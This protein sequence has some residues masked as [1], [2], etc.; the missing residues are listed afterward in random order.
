MGP[1]RKSFQQELNELQRDLIKMASLVERVIHDAVKSL[2]EKDLEL[3]EKIVEGDD[4]ID[5]FNLSIEQK[6][7]QLLALQQPMASDLRL[8]GTALKIITDLER[9]ADHALNIAQ[10]TIRLGGE[11]LI[12]PLVDIPRMAEIARK[13]V[14]AAIDAYVTGDAELA[15][16]MIAWDDEVDDLRDQ[17]FRELL[18]IMMEDPRTI[19]QATNL[20]LVSQHLERI[21]DHATNFGGWIIYMVTGKR[22]EAAMLKNREN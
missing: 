17:V 21:A 1:A 6:C 18:V 7:L 2:A 13:M 19:R 16:E 4:A 3:A 8:I 20:L 10:I 14:R 15:K 9:M 11:E 12:K 22:I 5:Q